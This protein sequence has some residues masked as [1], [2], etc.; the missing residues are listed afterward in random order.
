MNKK[1]FD[2]LMIL[3]MAGLLIFLDKF[4]LPVK[5]EKFIFILLLAFYYL[6][7]MS[8]RKFKRIKI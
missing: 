3:S 6:G 5:Y 4:E 7:Q 8:E 1:L 2:T